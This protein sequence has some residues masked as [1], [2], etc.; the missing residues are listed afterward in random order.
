M[1]P[2]GYLAPIYYKGKKKP[3][4]NLPDTFPAYNGGFLSDLLEDLRGLFIRERTDWLGALTGCTQECHFAVQ[5]IDAKN[6][7]VL[8]RC[9]EKSECM[10]RMCFA[11]KCRPF[12]VDVT[13]CFDGT[14]AMRIERDYAC[15]MC[16]VNRPEAKIFVFDENNQ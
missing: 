15:T 14:L 7:A 9:Q 12:F 13:N 6:G 16:C 3:V 2:Q 4:K 10:S 5:N 8:L 1:T 11:G